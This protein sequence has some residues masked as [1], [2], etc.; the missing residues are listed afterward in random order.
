MNGAPWTAAYQASL[1]C[2]VSQSLLKSIES[3]M[4]SNHL[5]PIAFFSS[6]PQSFPATGSFPMSRLFTSSIR[7]SAF[8]ISPSNEYSFYRCY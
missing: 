4:L 3:V 6:C 1:S 5:I 2:T 8:S 7:G